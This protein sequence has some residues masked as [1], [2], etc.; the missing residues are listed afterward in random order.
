MITPPHAR[1]QILSALAPKAVEHLALTDAVGMI[2]AEDIHAPGMLPAFDNSAMDGFA[3]RAADTAGAPAA[4][5]VVATLAAGVEALR[6]GLPGEAVRIMTGAMLPSGTDAVIPFEQVEEVSGTIR[7]SAPVASGAN[8]RRAGEDVRRGRLV[9]KA[10]EQLNP[11]KLTLLAALGCATVAVHRRPKVAIL[12]TGDEV[13]PPGQPLAPGQIHDCNTTAL[14]TMVTEAGGIPVL[15]GRATD[16]RAMTRRQ[17]QEACEADLVLTTGGVSM[18]D[19]DFVADV[20]GE[21]GEVVF[22]NVAQQPG[23]PLTFARING[24]P[25]IS[26]PGTPVAVLVTFEYYVRPAIRKLLGLTNL[27]RPLAAVTL[28]DGIRLHPQRQQFIRAVIHHAPSGYVAQLVEGPG[29]KHLSAYAMANALLSIPSGT[30]RLEP[31]D[32]AVALV[33][34][35]EELL[36]R[37]AMRPL[38]NEPDPAPALTR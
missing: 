30:G 34:Q 28:A 2:L 26:L 5:S 33:L 3:V 12:V 37:A 7:V 23:K 35:P 10:G 24:K 6:A 4:L 1:T 8:V 13:V 14:V 32:R 22:A 38:D 36:S 19:F 27:H 18:G 17:L 16:D 15:I 11:A 20:A 29:S 25:V 31:G 9:L 21:L